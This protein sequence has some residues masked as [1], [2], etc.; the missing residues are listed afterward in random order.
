MMH[1][2]RYLKRVRTTLLRKQLLK[3][4][5]WAIMLVSIALFTMIQLESIFYFH[6]KIKTLFILGLLG[7]VFVSIIF[8][9]VYIWR[10]KKNNIYQ[11]KI[12]NIAKNLGSKIYKEKG[13]LILNALQLEMSSRDTESVALA[14]SYIKSI[15]E[16][17][18]SINLKDHYRDDKLNKLK[19]ILLSSWI[20]I[21][22]AFFLKYE[23]SANSFFRLTKSDK[24]FFAPK[25]FT[26]LSMSG[27]IHIIGGDS[28]DIYIQASPSSPDTLALNSVSYTHLTLP[29]ILLV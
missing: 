8:E 3:F 19:L 11:Y 25:P 17:L 12:D 18:K 22:V 1:L 24:V 15:N 20:V 14:D 26:L 6:P 16:K 23:T 13:D 7:C 21:L 10:A 5:L 29:T 28:V 4:F 2:E 27:D 9:T